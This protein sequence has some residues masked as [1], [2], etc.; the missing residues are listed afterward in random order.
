MGTDLTHTPPCNA[1]FLL[2]PSARATDRKGT[3]QGAVSVNHFIV[4]IIRDQFP[5]ESFNLAHSARFHTFPLAVK[6]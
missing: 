5:L 4:C 3:N 6:R 1:S 2:R